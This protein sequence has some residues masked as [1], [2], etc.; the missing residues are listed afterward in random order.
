[1]NLNFQ[2]RKLIG[3]LLSRF[4]VHL[5]VIGLRLLLGLHLPH[6]LSS[7][8]LR[9][10]SGEQEIAGISVRNLVHFTLLTGA[11]YVG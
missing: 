4:P 9:Q 6:R 1:M 8:G 7:G 5:V 2:L 10:F 11:L 3:K